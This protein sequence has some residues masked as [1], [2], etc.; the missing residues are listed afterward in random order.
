MRLRLVATA[1]AVLALGLLSGCSSE[2]TGQKVA[3]VSE[4]PTTSETAGGGGDGS[5]GTDIDAM[6]EFAKC[7]RENGI[8][9]PDPQED[10]GVI[11]APQAEIGDKD[12]MDRAMEA[13]KHELPNGGAPKKPSPEELDEQREFAQCM[14]DHG[15]DMPDPDPNGGARQALPMD[16]KTKAAVEACEAGEQ[17]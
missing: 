12:K 9:M 16:D 7:M 10:G 3:S 6:R 17:K 11:A 1:T 13:C 8:D 2:D 5:A 4:P 14:R 15:V